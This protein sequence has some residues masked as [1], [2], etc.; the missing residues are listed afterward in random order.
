VI[1]DRQRAGD[2]FTDPIIS[3]GLQE[4]P[5]R[6]LKTPLEEVLIAVIG[7]QTPGPDTRFRRHVKP[8]NRIKEEERPNLFVEVITLMTKSLQCLTGS[9]KLLKGSLRANRAERLI[10]DV[11]IIGGN[12]I[13]E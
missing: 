9:Q 3:L 11:R 2:R 12:D 13:N 4:N 8:V 10:P 7:D 1:A 6:F 5:Y